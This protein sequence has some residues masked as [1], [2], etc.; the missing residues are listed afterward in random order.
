MQEPQTNL[1][2]SILVVEDDEATRKMLLLSL[3]Q[4]GYAVTCAS[5]RTEVLA[6]VRYH[7]FDLV[8]TDVLMP[9]FDGIEVIK[10]VKRSRPA[11][12]VLA[13]SGGGS[14]MTS[15]FTLRLA[16]AFGTG[17]LSI[18]PF[19]LQELLTAVEKAL[20]EKSAAEKCAQ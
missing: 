6:L 8:L 2:K 17:V 1:N 7:P 9:E 20:T 10:A 16:K 19:Y 5:G 14:S 13:L 4:A 15:H 18:K 3:Q 11:T 12:P